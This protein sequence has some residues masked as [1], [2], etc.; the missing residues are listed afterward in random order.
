MVRYS[1]LDVLLKKW[2]FAFVI[3]GNGQIIAFPRGQAK[4]R[5][6]PTGDVVTPFALMDARL[7]AASPSRCSGSPSPPGVWQPMQA[8]FGFRVQMLTTPSAL[9]ET[10]GL[11]DAV[12]AENAPPPAA[13]CA[14]TWKDQLREQFALAVPP[15]PVEE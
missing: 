15:T 3:V 2:G 4:R 6:F 7:C 9:Y 1:G 8:P 10:S 5:L 14:C 12:V 11:N 13:F